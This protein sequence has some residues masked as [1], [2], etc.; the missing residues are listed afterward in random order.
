[1]GVKVT[2]DHAEIRRWAERRGGVPAA[3]R[4][5]ACEDRPGILRI[6]MPSDRARAQLQ[7]LTWNDFFAAL[8]ANELAL[9]LDE[10]ADGTAHRFVSRHGPEQRRHRRGRTAA[11]SRRRLDAVTLLERQHRRIE[12]LFEQYRIRED[13]YDAKAVLYT[14]IADAIAAH[15]MIEE[16][17]FYPELVADEPADE[18]FAVDEEHQQIKRVLADLLVM[19]PTDEEFDPTMRTLE[20]LFEEHVHAE[21]VELFALLDGCDRAA[22][23]ELGARM[24]RVYDQLLQTEPRFDV[25]DD[26]D[27]A[28][29]FG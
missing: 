6:V 4:G 22:M 15:A 2:I 26:L 28:A 12:A 16:T 29:S 23:L 5:S 20:D 8:E 17:I 24:Q 10:H 13:D 18:L 7:M 19:S 14:Q 27:A 3:I 9:A 11:R 1:M 25:A 21:E